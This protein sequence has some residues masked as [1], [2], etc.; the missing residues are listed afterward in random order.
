MDKKVII[1]D[2]D[3][4]MFDTE[5]LVCQAQM[6][7]AKKLGVPFTEDY[8]LESV[9][10]SDKDCLVK[11]T[12]DFGDYDIAYQLSNDYRAELHRL[13]ELNGVP[14]K[15]G[16]EALLHHFKELDKELILASSNRHYDINFFL[17]KEGL[18]HYFSRKISGEDVEFAKPHPAIFERAHALTN[19]EK[20]ACLI[21]EDS[22]NGVRSAFS[23]GIDVIMVP[24]L[25]APNEEARAKTIAIVNDLDEI[26]TLF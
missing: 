1:F 9:G 6:S 20:E 15:K 17:E 12:E 26:R 5:K 4:L 10:M 2:M 21:L 14:H 11:Y 16:L 7:I 25:I 19:H 13:I 8:Y 18:S 23:A 22:L 3:G 24:D